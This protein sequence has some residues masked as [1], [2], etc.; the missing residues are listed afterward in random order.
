M[1][2]YARFENHKKALAI[3]ITKKVDLEAGVFES[4]QTVTVASAA[5]N[6]LREA[7]EQVVACRRVLQHSYIVGYYAENGTQE[8]QLFEFQQQMLESNTEALNQLTEKV[9][10]AALSEEEM[11]RMKNLTGCVRTHF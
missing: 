9:E 3:A 8:H 2:N 5:T 1:H 4:C 11:A 10:K 7:F 6:C